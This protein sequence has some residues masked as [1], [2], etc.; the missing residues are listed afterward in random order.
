E[1]SKGNGGRY[2]HANP[3]SLKAQDGGDHMM[4]NRDYAWLMISRQSSSSQAHVKDQ[5][6]ETSKRIEGFTWNGVVHFGKRGKLNPRY[7]RAVKVLAKKCY[8][9]EPLAIS[10][11]GLHID[12]KLRSVEEPIKIMD[13]EVKSLKQS[14][15]RI[16][17]VWWN[18]RR[19]PE[20]TWEHED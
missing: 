16:V 12:D 14:R 9:D 8:S 20:F 6:N 3:V 15:I 4:M 13:Q 18:S 1:T 10:L 2:E 17:K 19:G 11:D 7:V 5:A